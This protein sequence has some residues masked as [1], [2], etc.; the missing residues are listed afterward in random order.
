[1]VVA[2]I[3]KSPQRRTPA[4][5]PSAGTRSIG[6]VVLAAGRSTRFRS[7]RSKL[8]HG[9]GGRPIIRWLLAALRAAGVA[10]VVVVVAPAADEL[11][12]V[13]GADV[14]FAVQ[15]QPRGTGH[16]V[17]AAEAALRGFD[18]SV[19]VLNGDLP[20]LRA[21]T[22]RR[23]IERHQ[24]AGAALTLLTATV[25]DPSGWGRIVRARGAVHGIVEERDA[26]PEQ[27]AVREVNVG[28]Y[29]VRAPRLFELLHGVQPDNAQGEIYLTDI[30][31]L[32]RSRPASRS[33]TWR[34][35]SPR[36][37]RSTRERSWQRWRK[38]CERRSTRSGWRRA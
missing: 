14:E 11:R 36:S 1:L 2:T 4:P 28:L 5:N 33:P 37:G 16:A 18:G 20:F 32:A 10:P 22:V 8:V 31:G 17:L 15:R 6:A 29:C 19:L 9:L 34:S 24:S 25:A 3:N 30:V 21:D 26:N 12:A 23:V 35:T 13:C 7:A 38:S 27:R